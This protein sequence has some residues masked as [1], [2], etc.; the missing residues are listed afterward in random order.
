MGYVAKEPL[1]R[2]GEIVAKGSAVDTEGLSET[3]VQRLVDLGVIEQGT[4]KQPGE[5]SAAAGEQ[6]RSVL[7]RAKSALGG[8]NGQPNA[9]QVAADAAAADGRQ[10]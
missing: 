5:E 3:D 10:I 4:P 9:D 7:E 1:T 2:K 6:S 8:H